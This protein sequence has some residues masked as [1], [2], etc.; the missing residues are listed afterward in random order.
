MSVSMLSSQGSRPI[1]RRVA[2]CVVRRW[3]PSTKD[4]SSLHGPAQFIRALPHTF[5]HSICFCHLIKG[6]VTSGRERGTAT[7]EG[8]DEAINQGSSAYE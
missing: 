5:A 4:I 6:S 2:A 8:V 3:A 7:L 1:K